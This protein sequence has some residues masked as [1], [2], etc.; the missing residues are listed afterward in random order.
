MGCASEDWFG[1]DATMSAMLE[2]A[3]RLHEMGYKI[4]PLRENS[5]KPIFKEWPLMEITDADVKHFWSGTRKNIGLICDGLVLVDFDDKEAARHW[6]AKMR[7]ILKTVSET[8]KGIHA[9]FRGE[10]R[11]GKH[12]YG[13]LRGVGGYVVAPHSVVEGWEYKF[14]DG[15]PLVRPEELPEFHPDMVEPKPHSNG[16]QKAV[17]H[18]RS[19]IAKITSIQGENGSAGLC[20]VVQ[21]CINGGLGQAE[22]MQEVIL[23]NQSGAAVPEWSLKEITH[24]V[25]RVYSENGK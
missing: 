3:Q 1:I 8:R 15:H 22:A 23:W 16:P 25:K 11:N 9:F 5:K 18:V 13:D 12:K 10:S 17:T 20:R 21:A 2:S 4:H 6:Y 19:Y 14:V 7:G 24:A